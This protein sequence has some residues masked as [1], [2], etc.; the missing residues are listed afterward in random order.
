MGRR[1]AAGATPEAD[2]R[3]VPPG[4]TGEGAATGA[5]ATERGPGTAA[6]AATGAGAGAGA[7]TGA[8]TAAA[9]ATATGADDRPR[10]TA[11]PPAGLAAGRPGLHRLLRKRRGALAAFGAGAVGLAATS[12]TMAVLLADGASGRADDTTGAQ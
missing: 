2:A 6:M 4:A 11:A 1:R 8:A 5:I 12:S 7:A 3:E 10:R 9:T